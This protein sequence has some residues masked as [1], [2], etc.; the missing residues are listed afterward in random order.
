MAFGRKDYTGAVK[1]RGTVDRGGKK[2]ANVS[3]EELD[4]FRK[5]QGNEGLSYKESLR[6]LLNTDRTTKP[7]PP[8]RDPVRAPDRTAGDAEAAKNSPN[9][10]I[11]AEARMKDIIREQASKERRDPLPMDAA[12]KKGGSVR[13][14]GCAVRGK[15][16]GTMR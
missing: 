14:D 9:P 5:K 4:A 15:T 6:A 3:K 2:L 12:M 1:E 13:G 16:K 7:T 10:R 11:K 8:A